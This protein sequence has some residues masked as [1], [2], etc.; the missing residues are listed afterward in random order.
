MANRLKTQKSGFGIILKLIGI[1]NLLLIIVFWIASHFE[2][3]LYEDTAFSTAPEYVFMVL[4]LSA[5]F[6]FIG[7]IFIFLGNLIQKVWNIEFYLAHLA[8][9]TYSVPVPKQTFQEKPISAPKE[10]NKPS[11]PQSDMSKYAPPK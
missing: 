10:P 1:L 7:I 6:A 3:R 4:G 9:N 8:N 5:T 11:N 2:G